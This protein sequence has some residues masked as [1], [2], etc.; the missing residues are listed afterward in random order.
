MGEARFEVEAA[1]DPLAATGDIAGEG[2]GLLRVRVGL[3]GFLRPVRA[4]SSTFV[5]RASA[6]EEVVDATLS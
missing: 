2:A 6:R 5:L 4:L 3:G 1:F